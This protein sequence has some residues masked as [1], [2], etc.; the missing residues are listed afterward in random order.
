MQKSILSAIHPCS[1][2]ILALLGLLQ[3]ARAHAAEVKPIRIEQDV[4]QL[5]VDDELIDSSTALKRTLHQPKKD[6]GGNE[7]VIAINDE[8]KGAPATLQA[9]GT[10][11]YDPK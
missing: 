3:M 10:I 11:I 5:F 9:N 1:A 6:N 2:C 4:A 7:P 8:F